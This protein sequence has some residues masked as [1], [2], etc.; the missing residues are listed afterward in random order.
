MKYK[1]VERHGLQRL[2]KRYLRL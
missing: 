1:L 2:F